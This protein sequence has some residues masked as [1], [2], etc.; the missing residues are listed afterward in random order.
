[1][2]IVIQ[3]QYRN[4]PEARAV[5]TAV[6]MDQTGARITTSDDPGSDVMTMP[7][8]SVA[9]VL[10]GLRRRG[11]DEPPIINYPPSLGPYLCRKVWSSTLG[12]E[13]GGSAWIKGA[14]HDKPFPPGPA[15]SENMRVVDEHIDVW[16]SDPVE[17]LC[18]WRCY[19]SEG[20]MMWRERYDPE[21]D[22]D[23]PE[24]DNSVICDMIS[25]YESDRTSP[26]GYALDVGVLSD[27]RTALVEVND[28][29]A[30]GYYGPVEPRRASAYLYLLVSRYMQI[31]GDGR[32]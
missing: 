32:F 5:R 10:D 20:S 19:I 25:A 29:Y 3:E 24:P 30:L 13:R 17:W 12:K 9:Y 28:G 11:A 8:G 18:E 23:A 31:C 2:N 1:M 16:A 21:G 6:F 15:C 26:A 4:S 27:G 14:G 7:F 22:D